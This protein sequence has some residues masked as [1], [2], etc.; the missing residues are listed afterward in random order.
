MV[1]DKYLVDLYGMEYI[2]ESENSSHIDITS[3]CKS[4]QKKC[5]YCES[6]HIIRRGFSNK[7]IKD[8]PYHKKTITLCIQHQRWFCKDCQKTFWSPASFIQCNHLITK[9]LFSYVITEALEFSAPSISKQCNL[10]ERNINYIISDFLNNKLFD[11]PPSSILLVE[12]RTNY[13]YSYLIINLKTF[14]LRKTFNSFDDATN[15]INALIKKDS[16][17]RCCIQS[18]CPTASKINL[19]ELDINIIT[20]DYDTYKC[21]LLKQLFSLYKD[22]MF[23]KLNRESLPFNKR[24]LTSILKT[25]IIYYRKDYFELSEDDFSQIQKLV[26]RNNYFYELLNLKQKLLKEEKF[27]ILSIKN[28]TTYSPTTSRIS[29]SYLSIYNLDSDSSFKEYLKNCYDCEFQKNLIDIDSMNSILFS[30][31]NI[32]IVKIDS[33][34]QNTIH[35]LVNSVCNDIGKLHPLMLIYK[36]QI[37]PN[38]SISEMINLEKTK[39]KNYE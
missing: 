20:F 22:F 25:E 27:N 7:K 36:Y 39:F 1:N 3:S 26:S 31:M 21:F 17:I 38:P 8:I 29:L 6:K 15:Y 16:N 12:T 10:T 24:T 33:E 5:P 37:F 9:R 28:A 4:E 23:H 19:D 13:I 11:F 18:L 30:N 14:G 32:N 34:L 2:N 35:E